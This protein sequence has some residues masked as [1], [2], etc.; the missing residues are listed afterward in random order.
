MI[1]TASMRSIESVKTWFLN[2]KNPFWTVYTGFSKK[3]GD[4]AF[5]NSSIDNIKESWNLLEE[6]LTNKTS[7]GGKLT[8]FITDRANANHGYTEYLEIPSS[9][10][11]SIAGPGGAMTPWSGIGGVQEYIDNKIAMAD[12]DR[13]IADLEEALTQKEEGTGI[14]K[15]WNKILDEA[16]IA[17]LIMAICSKF[18]GTQHVNPAINGPRITD[19]MHEE[20]LS[21]DDQQ[22]LHN[23]IL[24]L[25]VHFPDIASAMEALA[26]FVDKNPAM[27][28]TFFNSKS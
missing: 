9:M 14:N 19:D 28:K 1:T 23:A 25:S 22:R 8:I 24:R 3:P 26:D 20:Q 10:S 13:R 15:V 2:S 4:T 18:L 27:A 16:P 21:E 5:K 7:G 12:K 6:F 17:E 11:A